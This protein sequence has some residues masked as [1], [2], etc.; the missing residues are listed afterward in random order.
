MSKNCVKKGVLIVPSSKSMKKK[1]KKVDCCFNKNICVLQWGNP[2]IKTDLID[3][4]L[5]PV[6]TLKIIFSW[7]STSA[8]LGYKKMSQVTNRTNF[9]NSKC[10]IL[11][12]LYVVNRVVSIFCCHGQAPD[13]ESEDE[14]DKVHPPP[15][16]S[17]DARARWGEAG[18]RAPVKWRYE[19]SATRHSTQGTGW[20]YRSKQ[21]TVV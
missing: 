18:E 17:H 21:F 4:T 10:C 20:R 7:G 9:N 1:K 11:T 5:N 14:K 16:G 3:E 15:P 19:R 6:Q 2:T 12:L 8:A 13:A